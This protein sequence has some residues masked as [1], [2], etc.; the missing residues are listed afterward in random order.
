MK[1]GTY[2]ICEKTGRPIPLA[3]LRQ[4]P[5]ARYRVEVQEALEAAV[6]R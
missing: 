1:L 6:S 2:G 3:R 4:V 5:W